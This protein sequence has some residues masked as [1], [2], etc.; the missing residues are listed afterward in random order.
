M[1]DKATLG[2]ASSMSPVDDHGTAL[3]PAPMM[4]LPAK[5][6]ILSRV[7]SFLPQI[8]AANKGTWTLFLEKNESY[9]M[10]FG[11]GSG[12]MG[13]FLMLQS[14]VCFT[15][16]QENPESVRLDLEMG[17]DVDG[18]S[19]N[20]S[21]SSD[22][23]SRSSHGSY[24]DSTSSQDDDDDDEDDHKS[25][26]YDKKRKQIDSDQE[27]ED[28]L[29]RER[30]TTTTTIVDTNTDVKQ[31]NTPKKKKKKKTDDHPPTIE[32]KISLGK[33]DDNPV[34]NLLAGSSDAEDGEDEN[35]SFD[36]DDDDDGDSDDKEKPIANSSLLIVGQTTRKQVA[37]KPKGP[38]ITE[39]SWC[40]RASLSLKK[41]HSTHQ[42]V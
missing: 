39:L 33:L 30:T 42:V 16:L 24:D 17:L 13:A 7:G 18:L 40:V 2:T 23:D 38:L 34:M 32:L 11:L 5:S 41:T 8:Q 6:D 19:S 12:F 4:K 31:D 35:K 10:L 28:F 20:S 14:F 27:E 25:D 21:S 26:G 29:L 3:P 22:K 1:E 36:N 15:D 9:L 37:K